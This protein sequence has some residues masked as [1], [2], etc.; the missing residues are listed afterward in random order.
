[1]SENCLIE[2]SKNNIIIENREKINVSGVTEVIG[3]DEHKISME[4]TQGRLEVYGS[5]LHVE[6]L[7]LDIGEISL[8]GRVNGFEYLG[9]NKE[10]SFWSKIF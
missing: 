6:K 3:F 2:S 4:T 9:S 1:M 7:S 10:K 8:T 5:E